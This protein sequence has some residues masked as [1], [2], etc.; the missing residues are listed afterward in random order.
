MRRMLLHGNSIDS[1]FLVGRGQEGMKQQGAKRRSKAFGR[2]ILIPFTLSLYGCSAIDGSGVHCLL[3]SAFLEYCCG[4]SHQSCF[5]P[6]H[7]DQRERHLL[8]I[9]AGNAEHHAFSF[10]TLYPSPY[11]LLTPTFLLRNNFK[12]PKTPRN[13]QEK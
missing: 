4:L 3:G 12:Q 8:Q 10:L 2:N 7:A 13:H 1:P 6:A 9:P 11:P 5:V